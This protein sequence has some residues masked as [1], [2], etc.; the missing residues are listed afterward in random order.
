MSLAT[1]AGI[2]TNRGIVVNQRMETSALDVYACGD[3]AETFDCIINS[4]RVVPIWPG[5]FRGG[6]IAGHN[7]AGRPDLS[8]DMTVMNSLKYFGMALVSAGEIAAAGAEGYETLRRLD[9]A[10]DDKH[11]DTYKKIVLKDNRIVGFVFA[12]DIEHSGIVNWLLTK[13]ID[14]GACKWKLL[15]DGF[16]LIDLPADVRRAHYVEASASPAHR[17]IAWGRPLSNAAD[18][19]TNGGTNGGH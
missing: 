17:Q 9:V 5:A 13:K 1:E 11:G 3:V 6:R 8:E 19:R 7:M 18:P 4:N 2:K 12:G 15:K 10:R 14:I 16:D